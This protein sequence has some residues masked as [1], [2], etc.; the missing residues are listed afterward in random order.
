MTVVAPTGIVNDRIETQTFER[1]TS[2]LRGTGLL[3]DITQPRRTRVTL[4]SSLSDKD[5]TSISF[6]HFVQHFPNRAV[7]WM[8]RRQQHVLTAARTRRVWILMDPLVVRVIVY[9]EKIE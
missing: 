2:S 1:N 4:N 8:R 6:V 3:T 7:Q 5:R 9:A